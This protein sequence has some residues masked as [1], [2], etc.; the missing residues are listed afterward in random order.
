MSDNYDKIKK[1]P[2]SVAPEGLTI[3]AEP[4]IGETNAESS[5]KTETT[6]VKQEPV[7]QSPAKQVPSKTSQASASAPQKRVFVPNLSVDRTKREVKPEPEQPK[8]DKSKQRRPPVPNLGASRGRGRNQNVIQ[9]HSIFEAG[10]GESTKRYASRDQTETSYSRVVGSSERSS[11]S[12]I[13]KEAEDS[14]VTRLKQ[15][16]NILIDDAKEEDSPVYIQ[17]KYDVKEEANIFDVKARE[18][19]KTKDEKILRNLFSPENELDKAIERL[20]LFQLPENLQLNELNE[21]QIGKIRIRKSGKIEMSIN[22]DKMLNVSLSVSAPFLQDAVG[23]EITE[24]ED[25]IETGKMCSLGHVIN[26]IVCSPKF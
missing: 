23:V 6:N 18:E 9:S 5:Q 21:G 13:K 22:D 20:I 8:Q 19:A 11:N 10:P 7:S 12:G 2:E 4:V 17:L 15:E 1:E 16:K 14:S 3:K 26:K 24:T 25:K